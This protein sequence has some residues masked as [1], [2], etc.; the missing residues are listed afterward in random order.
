MLS[1]DCD[2]HVLDS[3]ASPVWWQLS[4]EILHLGPISGRPLFAFDVNYDKPDDTTHYRHQ[5][6]GGHDSQP[7]VSFVP[8]LFSDLKLLIQLVQNI[9]KQ[10]INPGV[11]PKH[12]R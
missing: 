12:N 10:R 2:I 5:S 4:V 11:I 8:V 3:A 9:F 1:L 6:E 7:E